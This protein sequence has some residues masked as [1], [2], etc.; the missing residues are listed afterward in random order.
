MNILNYLIKY[1]LYNLQIKFLELFNDK[2]LD[3]NVNG[4]IIKNYFKNININFT[5]QI[6]L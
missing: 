5:N 6:I 3:F 4:I 1:N 2:I